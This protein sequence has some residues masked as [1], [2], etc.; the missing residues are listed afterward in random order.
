MTHEMPKLPYAQD[1]LAPA[2]SQKT[3][4]FHYGK[5]LQT[6]VDNLNKLVKG[7]EYENLTAE[8]IVS[9]A[10]D[11]GIFNNAGQ[12]LNHTMYFLQFNPKPDRKEP[13]GDLLNL[14]N[15]AWVSFDNFKEEFTQAAVTLFGSGWAWLSVKPDGQLVIT[16]EHNGCN[17]LR[18]GWK[19]LLCFDVWEHAYYLDFQNRRADHLKGLWDIV[20]WSVVENRMLL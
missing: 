6:Y 16:K 9:K 3:I 1:A 7:S 19:P 15:E 17:P 10:P 11:G 14:I 5:H 8:E 18:Y 4:E 12:V 20:D 2:I 13:Q